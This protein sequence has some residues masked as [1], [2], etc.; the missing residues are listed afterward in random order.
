MK[1]RRYEDEDGDKDKDIDPGG[2][3]VIIVTESEFATS[4]P[5]AIDEFF[6][7]VKILSVTSFGKE[8][9]AEFRASEQNLSDFSLSM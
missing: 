6:Q 4:N 7:S 9:Q 1:I 8:P 2:P 3:V 5:A